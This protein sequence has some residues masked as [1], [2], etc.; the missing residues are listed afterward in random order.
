MQQVDYYLGVAI[1]HPLELVN[2]KV[3]ITQ[4]GSEAVEQSM[5]DILGTRKGSRF[6]LPEY[7]SRLDEAMFEPNDDVLKSLLY[8][9]V[10]EALEFETRAKFIKMDYD[11][12][13]D[14]VDIRI[15]YR[16]LAFNEV[17]SFVYPFYKSLKN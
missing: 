4:A 3:A 6:M 5:R 17:K 15:Y 9:F 1:K 7:G 11:F 8:T 12:Y 14:R 2:G 13:D 10:V 16:N